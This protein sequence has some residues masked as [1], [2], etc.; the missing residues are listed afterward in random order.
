M[1]AKTTLR[2]NRDDHNPHIHGPEN[3]KSHKFMCIFNATMH[4]T[5]PNNQIILNFMILIIFFK[6]IKARP[7]ITKLRQQKNI[8]FVLLWNY[9]K[10][11]W[12]SFWIAKAHLEIN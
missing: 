3:L 9:Y 8:N 6:R 4:A 12:F 7:V 1:K 5:C 11:M 2:R 10:K